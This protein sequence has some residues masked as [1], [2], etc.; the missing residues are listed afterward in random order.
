MKKK[1][2][3]LLHKNEHFI[4]FIYWLIV[5]NVSSLILESYKEIGVEYEIW[6][7]CFEVFSVVVFTIE[8][9]C[10]LWTADLDE[11]YAGGSFKKRMKFAFSF[12]GLIDLIAI[13][14][15]YLPMIFPFDL[16]VVRILRLIR[17]LRI[18]KLGRYSKSFK[19]MN[20]VFKE[21]KSELAIT[22]FIAFIL[23]VLSSTLMYYIEGDAQPD[24]FN[25]IGHSFWWSISTL[26]TVGYGDVYPITGAGKILSAFIA[27][28][29]IGFV[30]LPTGII[31]SAFI[32]KMQQRKR[33]DISQVCECPNCG[34]KF[35]V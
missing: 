16:R 3:T 11:N 8:Y 31:S 4:K 21:T 6:F 29:G 9:I 7:Y 26:T 10:R 5:L 28:I 30:A 1:I 20:S 15:F 32:D 35:K 25:S 2:H 22:I 23:L 24:K 12:L 34:E 27:L 14:P 17:L 18:F 33:E 13:L 19:T